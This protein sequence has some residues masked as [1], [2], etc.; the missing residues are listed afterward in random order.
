MIEDAGFSQKTAWNQTKSYGLEHHQVNIQQDGPTRCN[1]REASSHPSPRR[2]GRFGHP[3][4]ANFS[5]GYYF[6][7]RSGQPI[8]CCS[9]NGQ[10]PIF[11]NY[12]IEI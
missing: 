7:T 5:F 8:D 2:F 11:V 4:I 10:T 12:V 1:L 3:H 9:V 6:K